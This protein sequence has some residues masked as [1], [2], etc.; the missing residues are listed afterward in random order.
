MR[1][2]I[3][4]S[5]KQGIS[6]PSSPVPNARVDISLDTDDN[7][8]MNE[9]FLGSDTSASTT[10]SLLSRTSSYINDYVKQ[11]VVLVETFEGEGRL[12]FFR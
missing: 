10:S 3:V 4:A 2:A 1:Y 8:D 12:I 11:Y 7:F 9:P 6:A 5:G